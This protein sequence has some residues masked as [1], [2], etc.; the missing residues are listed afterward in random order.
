MGVH[1]EVWICVLQKV[2]SNWLHFV[3]EGARSLSESEA[4]KKMRENK[5]Y[6][7]RWCLQSSIISL[8]PIT[9]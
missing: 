1:T 6:R 9:G 4:G 3:S 8:P 5:Y 2:S 7:E